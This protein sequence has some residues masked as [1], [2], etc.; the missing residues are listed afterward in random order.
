MPEF[1]LLLQKEINLGIKLILLCYYANIL[2]SYGN[3]LENIMLGK[4]ALDRCQRVEQIQYFRHWS[5]ESK[6]YNSPVKRTN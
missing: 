1:F 5:K 3:I 4:C 2:Q 6:A